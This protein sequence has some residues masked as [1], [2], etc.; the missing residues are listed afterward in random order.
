MFLNFRRMLQIL[1]GI[2]LIALILP[3]AAF[4]HSAPATHSNGSNTHHYNTPICFI[5]LKAFTQASRLEIE[6]P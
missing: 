5:S 2:T 1:G 3:M 6:G 4:A